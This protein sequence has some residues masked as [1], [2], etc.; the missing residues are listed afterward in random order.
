MNPDDAFER[1]LA[2]LHEAALDDARWPA[3][4]ALINEAC[5]AAGRALV[6]GGGTAGG[7][8]IHFARLL[9]RGECREGLAREYFEVHYPTTRACAA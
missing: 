2:S 7:D 4:G 6:V 8:R 1:I 3:T 9:S 5:G